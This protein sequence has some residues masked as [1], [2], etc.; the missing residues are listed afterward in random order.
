MNAPEG[1]T[2]VQL[3][4]LKELI[5]IGF[6]KASVA[7]SGIADCRIVLQV[8]DVRILP[9]NEIPMTIHKEASAS[10]TCFAVEQTFSGRFSGSAILMI[11]GKHIA[12]IAH[13]YL[14]DQAEPG[15][16]ADS[17]TLKDET[18]AET[19]NIVMESCTGTLADLLDCRIYF[20]PPR[21]VDPETGP[22][23]MAVRIEQEGSAGILCKTAY[24]F[25]KDE[26]PGFLFMAL[27]GA[28]IAWLRYALD[29]YL[30][31]LA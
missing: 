24:G 2:P 27:S 21:L 13:G 18:A 19:G 8:P 5:N 4:T 14:Q 31:S 17:R 30:A 10:Q 28:S 22:V 9:L 7:L 3:D 15:V 6:G 1:F 16:V 25:G 26:A 23:M 11:P 29:D 20:R 12:S